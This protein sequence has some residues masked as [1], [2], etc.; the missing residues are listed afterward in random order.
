[1]CIRDSGYGNKFDKKVGF[2][3]K[4][5]ALAA[6]KNELA[7]IKTDFDAAGLKAKLEGA[8]AKGEAAVKASG[9]KRK[10]EQ[11]AHADA[12]AEETTA[13]KA[14]MRNA[15]LAKQIQAVVENQWKKDE[16]KKV[17]LTSKKWTTRFVYIGDYRTNRIKGKSM[18]VHVITRPENAKHCRLYVIGVSMSYIDKEWGDVRFGGVG[19]SKWIKCP[20]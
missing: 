11:A 3:E 8:K 20:E 9:D 7:L 1:M 13:P 10:E 18:D 14:K 4:A 12:E 6:E 19:S 2:A 17:I 15:K 5:V 16:F